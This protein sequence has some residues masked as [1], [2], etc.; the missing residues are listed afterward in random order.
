[1][2]TGWVDSDSQLIYDNEKYDVL[3]KS[4]LFIHEG[5]MNGENVVIHC[6]QGK[7][8]SGTVACAYFMVLFGYGMQESLAMIKKN[9]P[10]VEQN[11][12]F[13]RQLQ[14]FENSEQV[15]EIQRRLVK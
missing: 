3:Q 9:R 1:M 7:S 5:L 6:A 12:G 2:K 15:K 10:M 4:I 14:E 11:R 13:E 8:R